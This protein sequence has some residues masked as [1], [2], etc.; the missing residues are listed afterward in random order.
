[1]AFE[2]DWVLRSPSVIDHSLSVSERDWRESLGI[3]SVF[4]FFFG[5][6]G[7]EAIHGN[8]VGSHLILF[9]LKETDRAD[10][11]NLHQE[12]VLQE[13]V[14]AWDLSDSNNVHSQNWR[15]FSF[16]SVVP[17]CRSPSK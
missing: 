3:D 14:T 13:G 11:I 1:M 15:S 8:Q 9:M 10:T 5:S 12:G 2:G 16:G 17:P 6:E 4:T 7:E